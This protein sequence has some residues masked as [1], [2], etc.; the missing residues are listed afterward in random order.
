ME[1]TIAELAAEAQALER[2][3]ERTDLTPEQ[4]DEIWEELHS[5]ALDASFAD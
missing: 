1:K 5:L 3:L 4:R 2:Q